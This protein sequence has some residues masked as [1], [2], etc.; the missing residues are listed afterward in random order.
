M[1]FEHYISEYRKF[2]AEHFPDATLQE[3]EDKLMGEML[4]LSIELATNGTAENRID[5]ALDVMNMSI[6]L[7]VSYGVK[8]PLFAGWQKLQATSEKYRR[9]Q[10]NAQNAEAD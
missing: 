5:E 2:D 9:M 10:C 1:L 8:N 3:I 7:L 6:K 4:E